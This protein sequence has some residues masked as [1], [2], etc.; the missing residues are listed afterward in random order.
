MLLKVVLKRGMPLLNKLK[1]NEL[2]DQELLFKSYNRL[3]LAGG[4]RRRKI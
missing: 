4:I 3:Q 1:L 2:L